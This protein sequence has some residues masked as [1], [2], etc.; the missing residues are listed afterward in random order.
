MAEH[1]HT[2]PT[3][4][5]RR[6]VARPI[7]GALDR[8]D[9]AVPLALR[10]PRLAAGPDGTASAAISIQDPGALPGSCPCLATDITTNNSRHM[11]VGN[12]LISSTHLAEPGRQID[13]PKSLMRQRRLVAVDT[14]LLTPGMH[15][16]LL[17]NTE[18]Q[19]DLLN[20]LDGD[21]DLDGGEGD[22]D[23]CPAG[24]DA[25]VSGYSDGKGGC[26]DPEDAED[27]HDAEREVYA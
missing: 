11:A 3:P 21:P 19:L 12:G 1:A 9:G 6:R 10:N 8:R 25:P 15:R 16:A 14:V 23:C 27:S 13:I 22:V 4:T 20:A 18:I 26:G 24:D 2:T 17:V 7:G 5:T